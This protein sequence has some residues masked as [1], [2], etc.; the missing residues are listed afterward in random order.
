MSLELFC[1]LILQALSEKRI[2]LLQACVEAVE[3]KRVG[4][5]V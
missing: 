5:Q 4:E 1:S 2:L 3:V